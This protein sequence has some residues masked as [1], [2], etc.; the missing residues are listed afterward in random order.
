MRRKSLMHILHVVGARPNFMK[1]APVHQALTHHSSVR[2]TI[3][4]TGQHYDVNMSDVFFQQLRVPP[5]DINLQVGSGSHA[6][7]TAE[8]IC[9]FEPVLLEQKPDYVLVYGDVNSTVAAALVCSKLGVKVAHVEAGLRSFDRSMPEEINRL[10][11]DQLADLLFTPSEDGNRNLAREGIDNAKIHLV[12]NVMIDTL[13]RMLPEA[14]KHVPPELPERFVLV[15]LHRPSNVDDLD[16]LKR[17]LNSLEGLS[18]ALVVLFPVHPRTRQRMAQVGLNGFHKCGLRLMDPLPYMSFLALQ[19]RATLVITDSGG[20]QEETTY[21]GT[22]CLTVRENTE[23][24]V[25]V[26]IGTNVLVG[27]KVERVRSEAQRILLGE[28]RKGK[29]PPLWD[30]HAAERIAEIIRSSQH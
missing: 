13:I 8:I 14:Q 19:Q 7:Q 27:R 25:T 10:L 28:A 29:I 26:E 6:Q 11:T 5:P 24:P 20:I 16:W 15:T 3:V 21:L 2:Q 18:S 30:G 23:R 22:P 17:M 1:L 9:R 12:G 4:H